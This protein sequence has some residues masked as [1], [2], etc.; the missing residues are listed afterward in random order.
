MMDNNLALVAAAGALLVIDDSGDIALAGWSHRWGSC[1]V[2][3]VN[4]DL[5]VAVFES[6]VDQSA[7]DCTDSETTGGTQKDTLLAAS[8]ISMVIT[9][10]AVVVTVAAI[11]VAVAAI[12]VPVASVRVTMT[13][14]AAVRVTMTTV[15]TTVATAMATAVSTSVVAR[16]T[17]VSSRVGVLAR[18][19][20]VISR[21]FPLGAAGRLLQIVP[22]LG[23]LV[24]ERLP[25][26]RQRRLVGR[27]L[28]VR[29]RGRT[30]AVV[31]TGSGGRGMATVLARRRG[32]I[33]AIAAARRRTI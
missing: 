26:V 13:S 25:A 6:F 33:A 29:V 2:V 20:G 17:T 8:L 27:R 12:S 30:A 15:A 28:V 18:G 1:V 7:T 32:M 9:A 22:T 16:V 19:R 5:G 3:V 31:L 4:L 14:I 10:V 21:S 11:A 23:L 24:K